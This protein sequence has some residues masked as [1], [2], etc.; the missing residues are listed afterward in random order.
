MYKNIYLKIYIC[1]L[2]TKSDK[3]IPIRIAERIASDLDSLVLQGFFPN[4]NE[5]IRAGIRALIGQYNKNKPD[6][7]EI[8]KILSNYIIDEYQERVYCVVLFGSVAQM[9]DSLESDVDLFVL[10]R[11]PWNYTER[12]ELF[13]KIY[14]LLKKIDII[15][16]VVFEDLNAF[17]DAL[18]EKLT[19]EFNIYT[20]GIV[21]N[22][23]F[24]VPKTIFQD[25]GERKD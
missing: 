14:Q 2:M 1:I 10:T 25:K 18:S 22:G 12:N 7:K 17:L 5:C 15:V 8:S 20:K 19:F 21:L 4:R 13:Q 23:E 16:S 3:I 11:Q 6:R 24:P 9:K